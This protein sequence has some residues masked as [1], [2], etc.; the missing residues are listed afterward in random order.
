[1]INKIGDFY[2]FF[3]KI[4]GVKVYGN[5]FKVI[6]SIDRFFVNLW[7]IYFVLKMKLIVRFFMIFFD[8]VNR[9]LLVN[10]EYC[11]KMYSY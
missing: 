3:C 6:N 5:W 9:F 10:L 1:M 4:V 2:I 8:V 7:C 11:Y